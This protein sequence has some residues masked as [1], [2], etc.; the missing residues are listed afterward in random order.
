MAKAGATPYL[1]G[2]AFTFGVAAVAWYFLR[3]RPLTAEEMLSYGVSAPLARPRI[4]SPDETYD[5]YLDRIGMTREEYLRFG[6][7]AA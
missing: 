1:I 7:V 2:G 3:R 5:E 4:A 6:I